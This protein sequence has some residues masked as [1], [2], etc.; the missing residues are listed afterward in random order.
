[1]RGQADLMESCATKHAKLG[2]GRTNA[3]LTLYVLENSQTG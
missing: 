3:E 2:S 1:M